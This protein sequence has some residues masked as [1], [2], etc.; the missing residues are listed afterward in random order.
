MSALFWA[1]SAFRLAILDLELDLYR[2]WSRSRSMAPTFSRATVSSTSYHRP[3][4]NLTKAVLGDGVECRRARSC[5]VLK[6]LDTI[7]DLWA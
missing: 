4:S 1:R 2:V 5:T 3:F 6:I 7:S